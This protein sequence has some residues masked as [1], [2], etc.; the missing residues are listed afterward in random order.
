MCSLGWIVHSRTCAKNSADVNNGERLS[1]YTIAGERG[2]GTIQLNG[3]AA[4]KVTVGDVNLLPGH[5]VRR[6]HA[7]RH[8][9]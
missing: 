8:V 5:D 6:V 2:S 1:T 3:A 9:A 7:V 4:H